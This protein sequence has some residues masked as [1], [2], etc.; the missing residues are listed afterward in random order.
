MEEKLDIK[1]IEEDFEKA[2][3][4]LR[5][6]QKKEIDSYQSAM[7]LKMERALLE[8]KMGLVADDTHSIIMLQKLSKTVA[9]SRA[10]VRTAINIERLLKNEAITSKG[11]IGVLYE[12]AR[13][14]KDYSDALHISQQKVI[15]RDKA[16]DNLK[17]Q[18]QQMVTMIIII[19]AIVAGLMGWFVMFVK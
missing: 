12:A 2:L 8:L 18:N 14:V 6:S 19:A 7:L 3:T 15:K 4:I 11:T 9:E 1:L 17:K 5:A 10:A 16:L 13:N